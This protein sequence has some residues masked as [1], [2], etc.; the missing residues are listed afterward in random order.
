MTGGDLFFAS[1]VFTVR[2]TSNRLGQIG[3][4]FFAWDHRPEAFATSSKDLLGGSVGCDANDSLIFG[5][6]S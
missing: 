5:F 6:G 3:R 4:V 1:S 2:A